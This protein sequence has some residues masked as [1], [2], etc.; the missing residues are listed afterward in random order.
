MPG[1]NGGY[2]PEWE[3]SRLLHITKDDEIGVI[4]SRVLEDMGDFGDITSDSV[5]KDLD[6]PTVGNQALEFQDLV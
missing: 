3:K 1:D 4:N 6:P 2:G 5:L